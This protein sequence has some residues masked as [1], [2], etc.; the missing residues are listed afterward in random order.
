MFNYTHAVVRG[1][2]DTFT[3]ALCRTSPK[4]PINLDLARH[5]HQRYT[6]TLTQLVPDVIQ[7]PADATTPDCVFIEDT[8]VVIGHRV[9]I[10]HL[11]HPNRRSEVGAVRHHFS[12]LGYDI[13]EMSSIGTLDGGDILVRDND[14]IVGLSER[15]NLAGAAELQRCFQDYSVQCVQVPEELHLKSILTLMDS[16]TLVVQDSAAGSEI[17]RQLDLELNSHQPMTVVRVPDRVSANVLRINQGLIIQG[18][19]PISEDIL[20]QAAQQRGLDVVS[21]D[22]SELIKADG[23]LTCSCLVY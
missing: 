16:T 14:I 11:G 18:H 4:E 20:R 2:P 6:Q 1:I 23:A 13:T 12:N 17:L 3:Q 10:N 7:L 8:C 19:D 9:L 21:L 5:Q 15:T 22:M